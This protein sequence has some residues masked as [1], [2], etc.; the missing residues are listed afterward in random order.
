[1]HSHRVPTDIAIGASRPKS[2]S[3]Y[4]TYWTPSRENAVV[5]KSE[6]RE[7][8]RNLDAHG[9]GYSDYREYNAARR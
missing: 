5:T 1:L 6:Q 2:Q 9:T 7:G 4:Q 3:F 8:V